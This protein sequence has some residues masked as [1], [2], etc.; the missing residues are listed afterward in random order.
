MSTPKEI[1][2]LE[3]LLQERNQNIAFEADPPRDQ[4]GTWWID[5]K[6]LATTV[7]VAWNKR[8]GFGLF[9]DP[10]IGYGEH[11]NEV[12]RTVDFACRRLLQLF[13][14]GSAQRESLAMRL[15]NLR[16]LKQVSQVELSDKLG[17]NQASI[18]KFEHR[19]DMKLG[20]VLD[21]VRAI[22]GH[23][24]LKVHFPEFD[25]SLATNAV[26]NPVRRQVRDG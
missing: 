22:G 8:F 24:E 14:L 20:T 26:A 13:E 7:N 12:Y 9:T 21:Y 17:I 6:L 25:A 23:L 2:S 3:R 10:E 18:S 19:A 16:K 15:D 4:N 5:V 1:T 11:P